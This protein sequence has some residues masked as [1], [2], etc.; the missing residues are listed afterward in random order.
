M[1]TPVDDII[2]AIWDSTS[3][4]VEAQE[5][6]QT[7]LET[8]TVPPRNAE[9]PSA[10]KTTLSELD[11]AQITTQIARTTGSQG[12]FEEAHQLLDEADSVYNA[13]IASADASMQYEFAILK[14]RL[15]LERGRVYNSG[16]MPERAAPHFLA[17]CNVV[18]ATHISTQGESPSS[19]SEA[20][21]E[22]LSYLHVDALHMLAIV[23]PS[24]ESRA[25]YAQQGIAIARELEQGGK[26]HR[27]SRSWL[28]PLLNNLGW[29]TAEAGNFKRAIDILA[30]AVEVRRET[31]DGLDKDLQE[32][33]RSATEMDKEWKM[34]KRAK[35]F[36]AWKVAVWSVGHAQMQ[37]GLENDAYVTLTSLLD[38]GADGPSIREDLANLCCKK[39]ESFVAQRDKPG[40]SVVSEDGIIYGRMAVAHANRALEL[41][42]GGKQAERLKDIIKRLSEE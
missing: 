32:M 9:A 15:E 13:N 35:A 38:Q 37:A 23:S 31:L 8:S 12:G 30:E 28:G 25:S 21:A 20:A 22:V 7:L 34:K 6:F 41:G 42:V 4:S 19:E 36:N 3:T 16:G 33:G 1:Q 26:G 2:F 29:E 17:A 5:S 11:K 24:N 18:A 40:K 39:A 27:R 14:T 10:E